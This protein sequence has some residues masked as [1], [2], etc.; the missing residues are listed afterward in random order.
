[1]N[2]SPQRYYSPYYVSILL[3]SAKLEG[4]GAGGTPMCSEE[5]V[6]TLRC[7]I[8]NA[9]RLLFLIGKQGKSEKTPPS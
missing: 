6:Q 4:L 2:D 5:A 8:Y 3:A 9:E 7:L 1:M